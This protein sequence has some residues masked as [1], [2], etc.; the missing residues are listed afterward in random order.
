MQRRRVF[1]SALASGSVGLLAG[2]RGQDTESRTE[3]QTVTTSTATPK[4]SG[5]AKVS[6]EQVAKLSAT[7]GEEGGLFGA[8]TAL[9]GDGT[10]ALVGAIGADTTASQRTGCAYL[11]VADERDWRQETTLSIDDGERRDQFGS[12]V[13]LT[14]DGETALIGC[15]GDTNAKGEAAGTAI[16]FGRTEGT[17]DSR[18]TLTATDGAAGDRFGT[19]VAIDAAGATALVGA[20]GEAGAEGGNAG[21]AY[22]FRGDDKWTVQTK[23]TAGDVRAGDFLGW[24]VAL[25][26][27]GATA[28]LGAPGTERSGRRSVGAGYVYSRAEGDWSREATL[29]ADDGDALDFFGRAVALS[30]DG[31]VAL[32]GAENEED[33]NGSG[34][35]K[36]T[37]A[38]AAYVF[39][40]VEGSWTQRAKLATADGDPGDQFG[41]AV[42][43][44]ADGQRAV[45]TAQ[46]D[47]DPNGQREGE[48]T[49]G[50]GSAYVFEA[51]ADGWAQTAKFAAADG[52]SGDM[53]GRSIGLDRS[54]STVGVGAQSDEDPNGPDGGSAY[55]FEL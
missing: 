35:E 41:T 40:R 28:L 5:T 48:P 34:E 51:T 53:F 32:V 20:F 39:E 21:A 50:A 46:T 6:P 15:Q 10:T 7:D 54:G 13:T 30:Q 18:A 17:W 31:R 14:R 42:A 47:D 43:L 23:L 27:D 9:S 8:S 4:P 37:A 29:T 52:D 25:S 49:S 45:V 22:V 1:L 38:G 19:D 26:G 16:V 12:A 24:T 3:P 44:G 11:Y 55:V 33:P 2:C 36:G